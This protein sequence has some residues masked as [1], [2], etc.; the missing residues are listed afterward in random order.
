MPP[1]ILANPL[2]IAKLGTSDL[3]LKGS[4]SLLMDI[5]KFVEENIKRRM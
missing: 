3:K 1:S 5:I 4:S 2:V